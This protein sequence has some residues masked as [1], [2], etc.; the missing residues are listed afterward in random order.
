[1]N[2]QTKLYFKHLYKMR[3]H[4]LAVLFGLLLI[5]DM[6][7]ISVTGYIIHK[8]INITNNHRIFLII[9]M[10]LIGLSHGN[11]GFDELMSIRGNRK[12]YFKGCIC[13][14]LS[15]CFVLGIVDGCVLH[16]ITSIN[17]GINSALYPNVF[18]H[19]VYYSS[20]D[21]VRNIVMCIFVTSLGFLVGSISYRLPRKYFGAILGALCGMLCSISYGRAELGLGFIS[22]FCEMIWSG[23]SLLYLGI[24]PLFII[25]SIVLLYEAP[26]KAYTASYNE[27][28]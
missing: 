19:H 10:F 5:I 18:M 20:L 11:G 15:N 21:I 26:I 7:E 16:L 17:G 28:K 14:I 22:G 25:S 12:A 8:G 9:I 4:A 27:G 3:P 6:M 24:S 23:S 2:K 13:A 1:M